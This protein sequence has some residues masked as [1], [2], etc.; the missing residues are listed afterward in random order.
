[1]GARWPLNFGEFKWS[2]KKEER[3]PLSAAKKK[4]RIS[5]ESAAAHEHRVLKEVEDVHPRNIKDQATADPSG[6]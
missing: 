1:M 3:F 2:Q 5:L 6:N 4:T